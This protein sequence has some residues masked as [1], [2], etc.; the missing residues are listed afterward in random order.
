MA[1]LPVTR[2][3]R[4]ALDELEAL[5]GTKGDVQFKLVTFEGESFVAKLEK[6]AD[7]AGLTVQ[8]TPA[9]C[10]GVTSCD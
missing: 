1:D 9:G 4:G 2:A 5:R 3:L 8:A 6:D 7:G 10:L